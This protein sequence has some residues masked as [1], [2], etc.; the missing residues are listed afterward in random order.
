MQRFFLQTF[1]L[2][3]KELILQDEEIIYQLVKVLRSKSWD[4]VIFFDGKTLFD[5]VY[6]VRSIDKKNIIFVFVS[7]IEKFQEQKILNLYQSVPNKIDKI[8]DIIQKWTEIW[9][10]NFYFFRSERSQDLKLSENKVLRFEKIIQE[11]SEQSGRNIIPQIYFLEKLNLSDMKGK[12][13]FF[14]TDKNTS[15]KLSDIS[16]DFSQEINIFVGPE[17]G[18]SQKENDEF[19]KNNFLKI[20]LGNNILRTQTTGVVT[21]FYILQK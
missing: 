18:F 15:Q 20:Y 9:Y 19:L 3:E 5:Y 17:W 14:H 4:Q 1:Y 12:N 21:W 2:W 13:I 11:A 6:E 10:N 7:K 8:E 16:F